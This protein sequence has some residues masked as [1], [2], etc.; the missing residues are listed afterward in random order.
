MP[1]GVHLPHSRTNFIMGQ[2]SWLDIVLLVRTT[3]LGSGTPLVGVAFFKLSHE[4]VNG[5]E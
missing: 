1:S 5:T 4:Y 2:K 3:G